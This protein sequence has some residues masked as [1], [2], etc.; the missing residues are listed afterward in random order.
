M[1]YRK[2][3]RDFKSHKIQ[4]LSI[5]LL[6][7]IGMMAYAGIGA[8]GAGMTEQLDIYYNQTNMADA[9]VYGDNFST[10]LSDTINDMEYTENVERQMVLDSIV[11][12]DDNPQLTTH[13]LEKNNISK[14]YPV[15]GSDFD[16]E[17]EDGIWLDKRFADANNLSIGDKI[18]FTQ[19]NL[20]MNKTIRGL[21]YSPEY[22]FEQAAGSITPDFKKYGYAYL[23]YKAYPEDIKYN[24]MLLDVDN[25]V[26][27]TNYENAVNRKLE[28]NYATFIAQENHPSVKQFQ[29]EIEQQ[30]VFRDIL[31][32]VFVG[33]AILTLVTTMI[34]LVDSQRSEIGTLKALGFTNNRLMIHYMLYGVV[35]V[36]IGSIIG[37]YVGI[38]T[39]PPLYLPSMSGF[40][41]MPSW[42]PGYDSG[43]GFVALIMIIATIISSYFAVRS[44]SKEN[45]SSTMRPKVP[46]ASQSKFIENTSLWKHLGFNTRWNFRDAKRNKLRSFMTIFGVLA[47]TVILLS[48]FSMNDVMN[49]VKDW[50]Y[51][52]IIHYEN[53]LVLEENATIEDI[54]NL[55]DEV[56]GTQ[57]LETSAEFKNGDTKKI[58]SLMVMNDSDLITPT[59][60]DRQEIILPDGGVAM[61]EKMAQLLDLEEGDTF[62]WHEYGST[63][64]VKTKL[65]KIYAEPINQGITITPEYYEE[66]GY[67]F[68]ASSII[69]DEL[70]IDDKNHI[71]SSRVSMQNITEGWEDMTAQ[72]NTMAYIFVGFGVMLS[73]IVLYNLGLLSFAEQEREMATLKVLGF[74][75]KSLR[76]LLLTQNITY[77]LIGYFLGIPVG[78]Y[79]YALL[80]NTIGEG[81]HFPIYFTHRVLIITFI[82]TIG[83]SLFVNLLFS[84]KIRNIDMVQTF[85]EE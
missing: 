42:N 83:V 41:T 32:V 3:L 33:I 4:F 74:K 62:E 34:R 37:I 69:T 17:D 45:P 82:I 9:W 59:N 27:M 49:D 50:E 5:F 26:N 55:T 57:I 6:A 43:F 16:I 85:K 76:R 48:A 31:P 63:N 1:L 71:V 21:G 15:E 7:F 67:H 10:N 81:Y 12:I 64:W 73:L 39:I 25:S 80:M 51:D 54:N 68:N 66:L 20:K 35:L 61:T 28:N 36:I 72:M 84:R 29:D 18:T 30:Y 24:R 78:Y 70:G 47:C 58:G 44:I 38:K 2:M 79:V 56:N 13:F 60:I 77:S 46:K 65:S 22:I 14:Y 19:D 52:D 53:K 23:S 11:E 75:T 40:Y 8:Q